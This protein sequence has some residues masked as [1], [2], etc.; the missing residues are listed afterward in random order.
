[1]TGNTV[2]L[3]SNAGDIGA[4]GDAINTAASTLS[5]NSA[6]NA[7]ISNNGAVTLG[8]GG[9]SNLLLPLVIL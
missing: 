1:M 4:S 6:G 9:S 5:V 7:Y 2:N 8:G 3:T